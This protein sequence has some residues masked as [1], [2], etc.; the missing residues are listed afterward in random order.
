MHVFR[1]HNSC[2]TR[3]TKSHLGSIV[4]DDEGRLLG[5]KNIT[6]GFKS[7]VSR[8]VGQEYDPTRCCFVRRERN[9]ESWRPTS[10][11]DR[12]LTL[13][14][15]RAEI[16]QDLLVEK[17]TVLLREGFLAPLQ[18]TPRKPPKQ[19]LGYPLQQTLRKRVLLRGG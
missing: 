12:T 3:D 15:D 7:S 1:L 6:D 8:E 19:T 13:P 11:I 9:Q 5:L 14:I 18:Q 10:M 4:R 16:T 17:A 2:R